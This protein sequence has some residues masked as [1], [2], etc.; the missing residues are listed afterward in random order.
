MTK[1][2]SYKQ[3]LFCFYLVETNNRI[4]SIE[5]SG[6]CTKIMDDAI[7]REY[8]TKELMNIRR[9]AARLLENTEVKKELERLKEEKEMYLQE[10]GVSSK[11]DVL[12]WLSDVMTGK[13]KN[14][15]A[16][17][18]QQE[19]AAA[20]EILSYYDKLG[21]IGLKRG[22][23]RLK[24]SQNAKTFIVEYVDN[25]EGSNDNEIEGN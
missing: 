1:E 15:N 5:K 21:K 12:K 18:L 9:A 23:D 8:T 17:I 4:K 2:L 20:K 24:L 6:Y 14:E 13:Y 11:D 25:K 16:F 22:E 10:Y 19:V 7:D 3:K